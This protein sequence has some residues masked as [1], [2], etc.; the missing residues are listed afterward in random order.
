[1]GAGAKGREDG[2]GKLF[3]FDEPTT[4]LHPE[5]LK[6][7]LDI[8]QAMVARGCTLIVV[9]HNLDLIASADWLID[10]GPE[11]GDLGGQIVARGPMEEV[12]QNP[13]S[14]TARYLRARFG[15]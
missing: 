13:Q 1:M 8:F 15:E 2:A 11:G 10:L 12:M 5:D 7:L 9:E 14:L 6:R 4:G 3:V